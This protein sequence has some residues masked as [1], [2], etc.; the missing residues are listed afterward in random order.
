M[1]ELTEVEGQILR[2]MSGGARMIS[3]S[4]HTFVGQRRTNRLLLSR[5]R[6]EGVIE[7]DSD[8]SVT[9]T[10][11]WVLSKKGIS[12]VKKNAPQ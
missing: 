3:T 5:L 4:F 12:W 6:T 1:R 2:Q 11:H 9:G 10:Q 7:V 8:R